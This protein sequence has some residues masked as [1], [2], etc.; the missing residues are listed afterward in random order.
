[1]KC[2]PK[3]IFTILVAFLRNKEIPLFAAEN[4]HIRDRENDE[5]R[6]ISTDDCEKTIDPSA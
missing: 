3:L 4:R 5:N 6:L 1:M 2:L